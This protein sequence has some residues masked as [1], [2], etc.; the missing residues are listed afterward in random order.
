MEIWDIGDLTNAN[1]NGVIIE[2]S[3]L[4][5]WYYGGQL[6][7]IDGDQCGQG[8]INDYLRKQSAVLCNIIYELFDDFDLI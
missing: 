1:Y 8:K 7:R 5:S 2:N 4:N 6:I 3:D